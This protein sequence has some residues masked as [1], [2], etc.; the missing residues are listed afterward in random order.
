MLSLPGGEVELVEGGTYQCNSK[1]EWT[2]ISKL[3]GVFY[4]L[5]TVPARPVLTEEMCKE[6]G[7]GLATVYNTRINNVMAG[8]YLLFFI[9]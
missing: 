6:Q 5:Y 8:L 2:K 1:D 7:G 9:I 4:K 3:V